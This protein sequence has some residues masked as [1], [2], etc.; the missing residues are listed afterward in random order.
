MKKRYLLFVC[1]SLVALQLSAQSSQSKKKRLPSAYNKQKEENSLFLEKQLW[2]GL[3]TGGNFSSV[4]V[5]STY[6]V[7]SPIDGN[8]T[9]K[10]YDKYKGFG[11]QIALEVSFYM[12]GFSFSFQPTY[13]HALFSYS[14]DHLWGSGAE[15]GDGLVMT[16]D[17]RHKI[18]HLL[19]PFLL[20]YEFTGHKLRPYIQAGFYEGVLISANK[21]VEISITETNADGSIN[22]YKREPISINADELFAKYHWGIIGGA[23][24]YYNQG[25]VRLNLDVQY[26]HG[27]STVV[28]NKN[29]YANNM[30]VSAGD[31][32]D[33]LSLQNISVS[34][35]CLFPMKFL[36]TGFKSLDRKK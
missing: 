35:G 18:D 3:K 20:K 23:G 21:D 29:R 13:Q 19:F 2:L 10:K 11:K 24:I 30:L 32:M 14:R 17:H 26:R 31:V 28:S 6:D 15:G 5:E 27:M 8:L 7:Y 12:K 4:T 34:V 36:G 33:D 16:Y 25:N 9:A 22:Q 1:L